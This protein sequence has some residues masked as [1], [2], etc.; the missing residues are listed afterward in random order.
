MSPGPE[1]PHG[2]TGRV[3]PPGLGVLPSRIPAGPQL[4]LAAEGVSGT[5]ARQITPRQQCK[6]RWV[7]ER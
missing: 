2:A 4:P 7:A 6:A 5:A 3:T 1:N